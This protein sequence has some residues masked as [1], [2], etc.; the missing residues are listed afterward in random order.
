MR[1]LSLYPGLT[2]GL[3]P[4][5]TTVTEGGSAKF[6]CSVLPD[7]PSA[8]CVDS[9][10]G[11]QAPGETERFLG[12]NDVSMIDLKDGSTAS[13]GTNCN[14]PLTIANVFRSL[15]GTRV[16]CFLLSNDIPTS[17]DEPY[18]FLSVQ[19]KLLGTVPNVAC[20][21]STYAVI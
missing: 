15:D 12:L 5:S 10:W 6:S 20:V 7:D 19:C 4:N 3:L 18:A 2:F 17:Q 14:S 21:S 13:V 16:R 11:V 9:V 1:A 8:T